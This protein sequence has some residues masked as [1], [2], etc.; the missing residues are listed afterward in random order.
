MDYETLIALLTERNFEICAGAYNILAVHEDFVAIHT[1]NHAELV[2]NFD[3]YI[4]SNSEFVAF[5]TS[6]I[7]KC[8]EIFTNS[9]LGYITMYRRL[10][11]STIDVDELFNT[12]IS[13]LYLE[14][15]ISKLSKTLV[16]FK[17][18][19]IDKDLSD[20]CLLN[21]DT[22]LKD[23]FKLIISKH[24][25]LI[26]TID[27]INKS[28]IFAQ[29]KQ[30]NTDALMS[31]FNNVKFLNTALTNEK[32]IL[33]YMHTLSPIK[34]KSDSELKYSYIVK[35]NQFNT[36]LINYSASLETISKHLDIK[37]IEANKI[38]VLI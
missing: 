31:I 27:F 25:K 37:L 1:I 7:N 24:A 23:K 3:R 21:T 10:T 13:K 30:F 12:F 38:K 29:C 18:F 14:P 17:D 4:T 28:Q 5:N 20:I 33:I 36:L 9:I 26:E 32:K 35:L 8:R 11:Q 15:L 6:I 22:V 19:H 2:E 16:Q 34:H